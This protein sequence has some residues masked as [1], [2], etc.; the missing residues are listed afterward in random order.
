MQMNSAVN[1]K[2]FMEDALKRLPLPFIII[3]S[4][5][6]QFLSSKMDFD[7]MFSQLCQYSFCTFTLQTF[8]L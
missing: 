3:K 4:L 2:I 5:I 1:L 6:I 8:P 7:I